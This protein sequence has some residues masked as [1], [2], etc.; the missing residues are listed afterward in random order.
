MSFIAASLRSGAVVYVHCQA[1]VNR[2]ALVGAR[3]LMEQGMSAEEA[4]GAVRDKR[5]GALS[6]GYAAWL[7]SEELNDEEA[8]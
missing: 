1:G 8:R 2:S 6:D 7:R 5:Q 3:V 4:I